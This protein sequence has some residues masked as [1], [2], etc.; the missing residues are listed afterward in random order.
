VFNYQN[1]CDYEKILVR[2]KGAMTLPAPF[3]NEGGG[4][5]K[6]RDTCPITCSHKDNILTYHSLTRF[7]VELHP[8]LR[9]GRVTSR[10]ITKSVT[11]VIFD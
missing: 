5:E 11:F 10:H 1:I 9:R 4:T 8:R 3:A 7:R 6:E 2:G